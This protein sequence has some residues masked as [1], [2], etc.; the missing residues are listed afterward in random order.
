MGILKKKKT[1]APK[2]QDSVALD[3]A[4]NELAKQTEA[5]LGSFKEEPKEAKPRLPKKTTRPVHRGKSFDIIHNPAQKTKVNST[6]KASHPKKT[7]LVVVDEEELLLPEHATKSFNELPGADPEPVATKVTKPKKESAPK[8]S[9][10]ESGKLAVAPVS[11]ETPLKAEEDAVSETEEV[12]PP[13][14]ST[15]HSSIVFEDTETDVESVSEEVKPELEQPEEAVPDNKPSEAGTSEQKEENEDSAEES[16]EPEPEDDKGYSSGE[17]FANNLVK[18]T[19]PKGY[20]P[21]KESEVPAVFDTEEYHLELHD[22]SKLEHK[23]SGKIIV[24]LSLLVIAA[25]VAAYI[26]SGRPLPF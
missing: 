8:I 11:I 4:M 20:K 1:V 26:L 22:W 15:S 19:K 16:S 21:A 23:S 17:L 25:G 10:H 24:L 6:L 13:S 18:E 3:S 2:K 5:L 12:K 7:K 9:N 14:E